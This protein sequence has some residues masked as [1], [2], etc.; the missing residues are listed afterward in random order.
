MNE[1]GARCEKA[2]CLSE[3]QTYPGIHRIQEK[4]QQ[5]FPAKGP[6]WSSGGVCPRRERTVGT[7]GG[8]FSEGSYP[9]H[10]GDRPQFAGTMAGVC[11]LYS[12]HVCL[13]PH[14]LL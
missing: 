11:A 7:L 13:G 3:L 9:I 10:T 2:I 4:S 8:P 12:E 5:V 14:A 6:M 1:E